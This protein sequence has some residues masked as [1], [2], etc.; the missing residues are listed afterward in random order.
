MTISIWTG[1]FLSIAILLQYNFIINVIAGA[2]FT[3]PV[4]ETFTFL[5]PFCIIVKYLYFGKFIMIVR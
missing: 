5:V 2:I 4:M 1:P 3:L